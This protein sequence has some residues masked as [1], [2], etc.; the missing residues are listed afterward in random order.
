MN[1]CSNPWF[2]RAVRLQIR[3]LHEMRIPY[4]RPMGMSQRN[5]TLEPLANR[6][7]IRIHGAEVVPF[8]QGLATND[9]AR[10]QSPGGPAS[11][12]AH[13]LNKSGRVLYDT[14]L[15]RTNNPDT[16]LVEC[17]R[18]A[19]SDFRRHLRTYRVRRRI[20]VDSVDDEYTTWVIINLEDP[21]EAVPNP[22]PDLFVTPD[23]RLPALGTRILAPTD[24]DYTKLAKSFSDFGTATSASAQSNYQLLRYKQGVGEGSLELPPG[25]CFPLE[26]NVDYLHGVSFHK[27]CYVGQE[28]TARVHHSGVIRKR[29]MPI[30]LTAPIDAGSNH[31]VTSVAGA[32]LGRVF[33]SA[34]NHGVALLRIEKVLNGR[35]ELMIDG[36]RCYAE[37]PD[38]WPEDLPGKR[39]LAFAE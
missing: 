1:R 26:A 21:A 15:Y 31:E 24:M 8:L 6:E 19:S 28:L 12:Y 2:L 11:M 34:Y 9:V 17:D 32:K 36:E 22:H 4:A 7:L 37:R 18:E 23:P 3:N 35:P 25:K 38:W 29:Y 27:G 5:F 10:I 16:L 14:I 39:R 30:R 33:G 13:F 20:D